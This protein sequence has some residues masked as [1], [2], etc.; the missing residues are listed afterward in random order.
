V[1]E[2][3][4]NEAIE[5]FLAD[6]QRAQ[7]RMEEREQERQ[8]DLATWKRVIL[9]LINQSVYTVSSDFEHR[10]APFLLSSVP[11]LTEGTA[12]F[13]VLTNGGLRLSEK[14]QFDLINGQVTATATVAG[15]HLQSSVAVK[16][17]S[18]E[19]L[20]LNAEKVLIAMIDAAL[21]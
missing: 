19:W 17:I 10:G 15:T 12:V 2:Q 20:E 14:L 18:R 11:V 4:R 16:D 1:S 5:R 3:E 9:H 21:K 8:A 13:R 6:P 7:R